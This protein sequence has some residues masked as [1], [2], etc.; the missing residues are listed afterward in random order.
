MTRRRGACT[1]GRPT[2]RSTPR[3]YRR[4]RRSPVGS[5]RSARP[6]TRTRRQLKAAAA[7][8]GA[9]KFDRLEDAALYRAQEGPVLLRRHRQGA[10]HD[11]RPD[12]PVRRE[13]GEPDHGFAQ[14]RPGR[15]RRRRPLQPRQPGH[16]SGASWSS[17][18]TASLHSAGPALIERSRTRATT[19]SWYATS[20]RRRSSRWRES[21]TP[22]PLRPGQ[23][24]SSGI[25]N[26]FSILGK[27][28][29][30]TDVQA[31]PAS[32]PARRRRS[33]G[34]R[35]CRTRAA[36]RTGSCRP[37]TSRRRSAAVTTDD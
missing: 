24:E 34:R 4:A 21:N 16:G 11:P 32:R 27:G 25:I 20:R 7:A 29:W 22:A 30:L 33:R 37:S 10:A 26:A 2:T 13:P 35:S 31:H 8:R 1:S 6:R 18:K 19:A 23:W 5:C 28:W 36:A 3:R 17:R 14:A 9:F 15:R 12:L